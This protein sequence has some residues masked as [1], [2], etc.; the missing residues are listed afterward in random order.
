MPL[1]PAPLLGGRSDQDFEANPAV[2]ATEA[3]EA[4]KGGERGEGG[5]MGIPFPPSPESSLFPP[6]GRGKDTQTQ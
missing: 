3:Q 5:G 2:A 1:L 6:L 4:Q